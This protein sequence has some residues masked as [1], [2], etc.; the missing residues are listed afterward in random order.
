MHQRCLCVRIKISPLETATDEF[1]IAPSS[2]LAASCSNFGA[3][4]S[5]AVSEAWFTRYNR[6]PD[7]TS[8]DQDEERLL[9]VFGRSDQTA[10]PVLGSKH[11][12]TP[13]ALVM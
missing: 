11:C 10:S 6:S 12:T 7:S 2:G 9:G 1:D 8:D 13:V 3:A 5:T 4:F